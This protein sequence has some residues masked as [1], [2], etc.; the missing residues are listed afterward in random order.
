MPG[1]SAIF[2]MV[3]NKEQRTVPNTKQNFTHTLVLYYQPSQKS[4]NI[5]AGT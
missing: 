3:D 2:V 4:P 5:L 1:G